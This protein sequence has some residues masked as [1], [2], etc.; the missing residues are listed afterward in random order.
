MNWKV[1]V[2]LKKAA[3]ADRKRLGANQWQGC[4]MNVTLD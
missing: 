1:S 2:A 3:F 4:K